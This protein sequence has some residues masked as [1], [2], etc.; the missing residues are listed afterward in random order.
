MA[1]RGGG[2]AHKGTEGGAVIVAF[3]RPMHDPET[4]REWERVFLFEVESEDD[5]AAAEAW[6]EE[7]YSPSKEEGQ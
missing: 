6:L 7:N 2:P 3:V 4:G 1:G 5:M